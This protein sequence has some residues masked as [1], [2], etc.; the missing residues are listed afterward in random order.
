MAWTIRQ[1]DDFAGLA[2]MGMAQ[3]WWYSLPQAG[4]PTE[5]IRIRMRA[6][7]TFTSRR[8][9]VRPRSVRGPWQIGRTTGAIP[10][11]PQEVAVAAQ[12]QGWMLAWGIRG[13]CQIISEHFCIDGGRL[14]GRARD[15][16]AWSC[17]DRAAS[18]CS[19]ASAEA[20]P[21][22]GIGGRS[23]S[24]LKAKGIKRGWP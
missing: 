5:A 20:V 18:C 8:P 21:F 14:R 16:L 6:V 13:A 12:L 15:R 23:I 17:P 11:A 22:S 7:W 1:M 24:L 4:V 2:G 19:G 10:A 9:S 3:P